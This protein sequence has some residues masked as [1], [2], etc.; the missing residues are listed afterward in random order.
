KL[1]YKDYSEWMS[2]RVMYKHR[3]FFLYQFKYEVPILSLPTEYVRPNIKTTNGAI[4]S[5][6]MNQQNRKLLKKY[7]EKHQITAF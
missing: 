2:H 5:F 6:T 4:I 7:V 1:I 3:Q